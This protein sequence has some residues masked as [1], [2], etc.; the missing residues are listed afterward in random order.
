MR[1]VGVGLAREYAK[2]WTVLV[3]KVNRA[4]NLASE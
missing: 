1:V 2:V 4:A 3:M